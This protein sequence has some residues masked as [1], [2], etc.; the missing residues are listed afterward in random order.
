M[1]NICF[2]LFLVFSVFFCAV[3]ARALNCAQCGRK[4]RGKY[5]NVNG[6]AYCSRACY[7]KTLPK[8]A[9][10]G[11]LL[12]GRYYRR[13]GKAYCT[14]CI[15]KYWPVCRGCGRHVRSG[16]VFKS[17]DDMFFC[18]DCARL[19]KCFSCL[20]PA[21]KGYKLEDGRYICRECAKTAVTNMD[22]AVKIFNDVRKKMGQRLGFSTN[23]R[24]KLRM[25]DVQAMQRR[26]PG[27]SH[28]IELGLF[29]FEAIVKT[30]VK[31]KF[32]LT[33]NR[34]ETET[35]RENVSYSIFFL[36]NTPKKKLIEVFAH[37]LGHDYMQ[38]YYPDV[39]SVKFKEG[40]C[41]L[42][43]FLMNKVYG[44]PKMN[45][46]IIN[47]PD[48]TYGGGFRIMY[49]LYNEGGLNAVKRFLRKNS[50]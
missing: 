8:C 9:D 12:K 49:G 36:N 32:T 47:N 45:R 43:A 7:M 15:K 31:N 38:E 42:C 41:E 22:E 20:V 23:H 37:E 6:K 48:L 5:I 27:Y 2:K 11:T 16:I 28:G 39:L 14:E 34:Q 46:R 24:I 13:D 18:E 4:I 26:S 30:T 40:F 25:V 19:P 33:G 10:C 21:Y 29:M 50:H 1:S 35:F 44:Q 17:T 3:A